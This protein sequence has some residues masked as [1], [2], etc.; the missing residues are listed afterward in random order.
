MKWEYTIDGVLYRLTDFKDGV[1]RYRKV[2][3]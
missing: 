1:A 3:G 2:E